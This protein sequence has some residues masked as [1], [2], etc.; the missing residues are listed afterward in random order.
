[1]YLQI[2]SY[3]LNQVLSVSFHLSRKILVAVTVLG[4][5]P[6]P[7]R[8]EN[9]FAVLYRLEVRFKK[10]E[11]NSIKTVQVITTLEWVGEGLCI[12]T[13]VFLLCSAFASESGMNTAR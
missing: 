2:K 11:G 4:S 7:A 5:S 3:S 10:Y 1:M 9:I 6:Q 8:E 13:R 12:F